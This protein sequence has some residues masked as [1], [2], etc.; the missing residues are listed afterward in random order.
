MDADA[1]DE[2]ALFRLTVR[3][4]D[5]DSS[6]VRFQEETD[7]RF[8]YPQTIKLLTAEKLLVAIEL[9]DIGKSVDGIAS[10]AFDAEELDILSREQGNSRNERLDR[11]VR[12]E[13]HSGH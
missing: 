5:S 9:D 7:G 8:D 11:S 4:Y 10:V 2:A 6:F 13:E 3:L 1:A 12:S